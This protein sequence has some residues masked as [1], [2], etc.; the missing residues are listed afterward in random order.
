MRVCVPV[1]VACAVRVRF[2]ARI[3]VFVLIFHMLCS[4]AEHETKSFPQDLHNKPNFH[5]LAHYRELIPHLGHPAF[6]RTHTEERFHI[7]AV[8]DPLAGA[9]YTTHG[10]EKVIFQVCMYII[11]HACMFVRLSSFCVY[12]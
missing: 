6:W 11:L 9:R 10:D 3:S 4:F 2:Y 5:A 8:K 12:K 7:E 1:C